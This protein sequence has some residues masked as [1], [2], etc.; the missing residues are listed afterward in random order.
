MNLPLRDRSRPRQGT[1]G[2]LLSACL[3]LVVVQSAAA[4]RVQIDFDEFHG[5]DGTVDYIRSIARAYPNITEL[6]EIGQS[7][8]GRPIYVLVIS[9]MSTGTTI[10]QYVE[11]RNPRREGVD[12]V[13]PMKSYHGKPGIWI[14][15]GTHGNEYTGTEVNL[16]IIDKLVAGYGT[17]S[18]ITQ[19]IDDNTFYFCPM[20]NP[21]GVHMSVEEGIPQRQNSMLVDD[22]E[23]GEVN[24]DGPDDLNGDGLYTSFRYPDPEGRYVLDDEDQRHMIRLGQDEETEKETY[25]VVREDRD[26]DGDGERG[27]DPIRGIDVNRNFP[28]G[29]FRDDDTQGGS[30][31]YAASSVETRAILEFFTNHTNILLVQSFHTSGGFTYR[32]FARWS[33]DQIDPKDLS[34]YDR[35]M[36]KKY[37]ELNDQEV[38]E[39][40]LDAEPAEGDAAEAGPPMRTAP[41]RT[42]R[43]GGGMP[44][45]GG[46]P[47]AGGAGRQAGSGY[48]MPTLWQHPYNDAQD[49]AYGFGIFIDWAYAQFGS[50]SM[51]TELWSWQRDTRGVPGFDGEDDRDLFYRSL[52]AYQDDVYD[53]E[54][55]VDWTPY[56][57][58]ELGRGEV[59]GWVSTFGSN[60]AI[61]GETL[62]RIADIHWQFELFK[63]GLMPKLEI[64]E[65]SAEVLY[66]TDN[67]SQAR[68]VSDGNTVTIRAGRNLGRYKVVKVTATV[69]NTGALAT[70]VA[71]GANLAGNRQDVIWLIGNRDRIKFLQGSAWQRLGVIDGTLEIPGYDPSTAPELRVPME[72][73]MPPEEP[74]AEPQTGNTREVTWL[75]AV[76]GDTPL[77]IVLS[78]QKGGTRVRELSVR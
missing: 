45:G 30:G 22:D 49:R 64:T 40:W 35:V 6:L 68:A 25:S 27:E 8:M 63:A 26:N 29:W 53:G 57:H 70:H 69:E 16:Y 11:L 13:T 18:E 23:D 74:G 32:P 76:E 55:F 2:V 50:Y 39:A 78:S 15:G 24:E 4:Q 65:A 67:T 36:G 14:D 46:R 5:H 75:I 12:N 1:L 10:D 61:P 7:N 41:Q 9:N 71:R 59:G 21:D 20:V 34:I 62:E 54:M 52:L 31:Y 58:P 37:L 44:P 33:D 47:A 3:L 38:P 56:N 19:L 28:E 48:E 77:R 60:N 51:T 17:D 42:A 43:P 72:F 66:T 73:G